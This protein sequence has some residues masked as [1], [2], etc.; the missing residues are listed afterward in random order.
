VTEAPAFPDQT[1][2]ASDFIAAL[3][4]LQAVDGDQA[5]YNFAAS[6]IEATTRYLVHFAGPMAART[7]LL[8]AVNAMDVE[9]RS[10]N[11]QSDYAQ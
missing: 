2:F 8:S 3:T 5:A 6:N 1:S 9:I 10:F 7:A 11:R 4:Q